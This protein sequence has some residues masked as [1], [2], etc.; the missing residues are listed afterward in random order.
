MHVFTNC[1]FDKLAFED[2]EMADDDEGIDSDC[3]VP[4]ITR[5][6]IDGSSVT[7][8]TEYTD[9]VGFSTTPGNSMQCSMIDQTPLLD[10]MNSGTTLASGEHITVVRM[11][12]LIVNTLYVD[13]RVA[14]YLN[15]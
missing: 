7:T 12:G 11:P 8:T 6:F 2:I 13:M 14:L 4:S 9:T 1:K 15:L 5:E 10:Y 3:L